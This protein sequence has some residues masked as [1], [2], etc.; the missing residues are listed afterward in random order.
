MTAPVDRDGW[1]ALLDDVAPPTHGELTAALEE[2]INVSP[3]KAAALLERAI[4]EG[5]LVE[6]DGGGRFTE[7]TLAEPGS[8]D[9]TP[10]VEAP[11]TPEDG[12]NSGSDGRD[13]PGAG[14]WESA[15][16]ATTE[17]DTY[18][19]EL[20]G[21]EQWMGRKGKLPFAPWGDRDHP[22][23]DAETDARWKWGLSEH[24]VD[25]ET[26]AL[27]EEDHRLDGRVFIQRE[28]DPYAFVDGD[29]VRDPETGDVHPGFV[30]ILEH[31]GW[32]YADVSTSGAGVHA[33]YRGELPID[34]KGQATFDLDT[35]PW[36]ANDSPP[37]V[38]IYANKHVNVATGEHVDGTPRA[39]AEWDA[40]ALRAILQANGYEDREP[41]EHD[42]D[43]DSDL[44]DHDP[45][46]T[47]AD[48]TTADVKDVLKAVDDLEPSDVR[49]RA[50]ETGE[51]S[52]GWTTWDPRYRTS[53]SGESLHY[54]GVGVFYDHREGE[55]FGVLGLIAAEENINRRPW[56]TLDGGDWFDA[57]EA[58]RDRG[59][60]IPQYEPT[61]DA[62]PTA[63]LPVG[64]LDALE[65]EERRRAARKRGVEW[66]TTADARDRLRDAVFRELR[67]GNATVLDAPTALGKS[68]TVA[69]EPWLRRTGVTGGAPVVH[70]HA[71]RDARDEAASATAQAS[72]VR[73]RVLKGR[74]EACALAGGDHDPAEDPDAEDAPETPVTVNGTPASEYFDRLCDYKSLPFST[75]H[76]LA[77][78]HNDQGLEELPC[79]EDGEC[80]AIAQWD[81][82]PRDDDGEPTADV[83]HATHPFAYVPSL[84]QH[85][86]TVVDEQPDYRVQFSDSGG[87]DAETGR[88]RSIVSAYLRAVDAPVTTW[89]E[90]VGLATHDGTATD[91]ATERDALEDRLGRDPPQEWYLDDPDA[92]ALAPDLTRAIWQAL[93][94]EDA[95]E[96]GRR[97]AT[98]RHQPPRLDADRDG[99]GGTWLSVVIDDGFTVRAVRNVPD[100]SQARAVLGLDAHPSM[101]MWQL[102]AGAEL[103]KSDRDAVLDAEERALWRRYERG[104]TTVQVGDATRPRSGGKAR[105]WMNDDRVRAVVERIREHE[106]GDLS[107][108]VTTRQVEPAIR[109]ILEDAGVE[110]AETMHY[111]N[112]KS[113]NEFADES[114]GYVYGCMDPGDG[115][116]LDVLAELG[117]DA[118]PATTETDDGET[119]REKGRAFDGAD[120]DT[121]AAVLASVRENHVAQAAGRYARNPDDPDSSAVVYIHTDAAPAG[122]VDAQVPGVEWLATDTQR[123]VVDALADRPSATVRELADAAGCTKEHVRETLGRLEGDGVT[124]RRERAGEHGAD[125]W[126]CH[127]ASDAQVAL[128]ETTNDRLCD[129]SRWSLAIQPPTHPTDTEDAPSTTP[130]DGSTW[131]WDAATAD[132]PPPDTAD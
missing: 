92:H 102:N 52:T 103:G 7:Y 10:G 3:D 22:D 30:A 32:T 24:Y 77:R 108:A 60:E 119:V 118:T 80:E 14:G 73:G 15:D 4:A 11:K 63:A 88:V 47:T 89:E 68:H 91:A 66:P 104:L 54:N 55:K 82:V 37:T 86:N 126:R 93:R 132:D 96:T 56:D 42:T 117:L 131:A 1:R 45:T 26:V 128:G 95:D 46:A 34:G 129:S 72:G 83:V 40:D 57:I 49:L 127:G 9:A 87:P 71:T 101:P 121:A 111:G 74:R 112:E 79:R 70:L 115:M 81:G 100:F 39:L 19:P 36:G 27:A 116:I 28:S 124:E 76:A 43:A 122:F 113:R 105:E 99:Y 58:A 107:T 65:P 59:A 53:E 5:E 64:R 2:R 12:T 38:E 78:E 44:E 33:Y 62:D 98:V 109:G 41:V 17:T 94:W 50:S 48:E 106:G 120:A 110:G 90:F 31:L 25:G 13:T 21:V 23:A 16:F 130:G 35:E 18:P 61:E 8:G 6:C 69:T 84:R 67:A 97:S 85:T 114:L 75:A 123:A 29:D 51:D 125:V 20:L